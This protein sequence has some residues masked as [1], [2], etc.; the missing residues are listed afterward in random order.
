MLKKFDSSVL[1]HLFT[2]K[3]HRI[4]VTL[5]TFRHTYSLIA[6]VFLTVVLMKT[7]Q[8]NE[9]KGTLNLAQRVHWKIL[10]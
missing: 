3:N 8:L 10:S 4:T 5:F 7:L 2:A 6:T 1:L 9:Y